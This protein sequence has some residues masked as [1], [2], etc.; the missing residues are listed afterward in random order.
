MKLHKDG[1]RHMK[2]SVDY[3]R[4]E[5]SEAETRHQDGDPVDGRLL[6]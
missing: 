1:S 4:Q 2:E 5:E 6:R 3:Y